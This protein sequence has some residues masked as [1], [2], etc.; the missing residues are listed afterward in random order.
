LLFTQQPKG[1]KKV[2]SSENIMSKIMKLLERAEHEGTPPEE[3]DS[4]RAKADALMAQHQIDRMDLKPEE[5]S[6][7]KTDTWEINVGHNDEFRATLLALLE[8]VLRHC[9]IRINPKYQFGKDANGATDL[10][11]RIYTVVGFPEDMAYAERIWF[12]VFKEF[13]GNLR[14]HWE[15]KD[16]VE[17]NAYN[18]A[19]AGIEWQAMVLMA[20]D[21]GD[22]RIPVS[23]LEERID[24]RTNKRKPVKGNRPLIKGIKMLRDGYK[25]VCESKGESY[26]Y[27]RGAKTRE[28]YRTSFARSFNS[29]IRQRLDDMR[30]KAKETV[31]DRDKFAL[32]V[33]DTKEKVDA[34][35]YRLFPEYDPEVRR[36]MQQ[37]ATD[38]EIA[39]FLRM[40]PEE[41]AYVIREVQ[42]DDARWARASNR[43]RAS[44]GRI[45]ENPYGNVESTAW[46]RGRSAAAKVNLRDDGEVKDQSRKGLR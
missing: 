2:T 10:D 34:E 16:S 29:T 40:T 3:A 44:Y 18:L 42:R 8:T 25:A 21:A 9:G 7:V 1:E 43:G 45:R 27:T 35:F 28:A 14:P 37:A 31:S 36:R 12:R 33:V 13:I 4:C 17:D 5:K 22:E 23:E 41:Q 38:E 15:L 26:D 32:A 46:A 11:R 20:N 6:R 24:W 30:A 39:A 19:S